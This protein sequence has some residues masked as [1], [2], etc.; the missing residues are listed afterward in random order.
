MVAYSFNF[1]NAKVII[2]PKADLK[3]LFLEITGR[4]NLNCSMC[5]KKSF[6]DPEGDMPFELYQKI[7]DDCSFFPNLELIYL[8][9]IGESTFHP[10]FDA[11]VKDIKARGYALGLSTNGTLLTD[12]RIGYLVDIGLDVIYF[13]M[14]TLPGNPSSLGHASSE[15]VL[16]RIK[17]LIEVKRLKQK[18]VPSVGVEVVVTKENYK[19]LPEMVRLFTRLGVQSVVISNL[20]PVDEKQVNSILYDESIDMTQIENR[21]HA[22]SGRGVAIKL[23]A[24]KF[25]TERRCDFD[26]SSSAVIRH[27]GNVSPCYRLLHSYDEYIFGRKKRVEAY[28][29]GNVKDQ[30]LYDIWTSRKYTLFRFIM[31][32]YVYPSCTDCSLR[33]ACDFV[34][35]TEQDCW[36][37]SPSCADCLWAR[38]LILCPVPKKLFSRYL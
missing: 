13:S 36:G 38:N 7:M 14:D 9:G 20:L 21:I 29:F 17:K 35:S 22:L 28:S 34:L 16:E 3:Y 26:E 24:F 18:E 37:N 23:P 8:G 10:N 6:R 11:I 1:W 4:C 15:G 33:D 25:K 30:S 12:E 27:D 2:E 19:E 5:F 32:N 31:K